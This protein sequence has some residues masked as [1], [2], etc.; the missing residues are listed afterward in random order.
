MREPWDLPSQVG[1]GSSRVGPPARRPARDCAFAR[2]APYC[3]HSA[4]GADLDHIHPFDHAHPS[5]GGPTSTANLATLCRR[6]HRLKTHHGWTYEPTPT[7]EGR[8]YL[9]TLPSG[10]R[11]LRAPPAPPHST[12]RPPARASSTD[13]RH[14]PRVPPRRA[15]LRTAAP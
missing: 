10:S 7:P 4:R 5:R 13:R 12:D 15:G 11:Y 8:S 6:H 14:P 3:T 1:Y 2:V 9:W